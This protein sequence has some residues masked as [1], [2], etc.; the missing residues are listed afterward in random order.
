MHAVREQARSVAGLQT[1]V[2]A[3]PLFGGAGEPFSAYITGPDL[4]RVADLATAMETRL[5]DTPGMG[6]VKMDL[7][8]NRPQLYFDIDRAR[9]QALGIS[10]QQIGDT[11]RV[12]AG[13]ADI[14]KYNALPGDGERYDI[15]FLDPPFSADYWPQLWTL[16]PERMQADA[17]VYCESAR[18]LDPPPGWE[19]RKSGRAG[20]VRF[21]LL[22]RTRHEQ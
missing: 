16:L 18:P 15:I 5:L 10:T 3:Y 7:K 9:S 17:V 12:L 11:V 2:N 1:Y 20:Q 22:K 6:D 21:Q 14:A 4:Y 13:G 19:I 8:M